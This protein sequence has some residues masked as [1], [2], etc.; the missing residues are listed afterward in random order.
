MAYTI[1]PACAAIP[2]LP[3]KA[4]ASLCESIRTHG[5]L[6]PIIVNENDEILEGKN[7][8][9]ACRHEG[10]APRFIT[11]KTPADPLAWVITA[12]RPR[13][14]KSGQWALTAARLAT[15]GEGNPKL[16]SAKEEVR[17]RDQ[18]AADLGISKAA[19]DRATYVEAHGVPELLAY[20][21]LG[22]ISLGCAEWAAKATREEQTSAAAVDAAAI[23]QL[24]SAQRAKFGPPPQTLRDVQV[25]DGIIGL[26]RRWPSETPV[27]SLIANLEKLA[28]DLKKRRAA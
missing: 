17:T 10:V 28:R 13:L 18:V 14:R 11:I 26:A 27:E 23:R 22:E 4:F 7:R 5:L 15:A 19:I 2:D 20:L 21:E 6:Q 1:H 9:R 25:L 24:A 12:N 8:W 16:T 3:P